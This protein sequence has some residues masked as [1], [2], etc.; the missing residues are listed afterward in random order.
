MARVLERCAYCGA[1]ASTVE[2]EHVIP[3]CLYPR[4]R[5]ASRV[6]RLTV[7]SCGRCNRGWSDD[8]A[9]F[10]NVLLLAGMPNSAVQEVWRTSTQRS[11]REVDG[12]RRIRDLVDLMV[13][14]QV[15][16]E[17]RWMIYPGRDPRVIRVVRKIVR[18]LS[19][20]HGVGS[21]IADERVWA[22]ILKY[23]IPEYLVNTVHFHHREGDIVEY[24]YEAYDVG[25]VTSMW[26]LKFY[27]SRV[28]VAAIARTTG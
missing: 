10:R 25:D 28:F 6:Q 20:H 2:R 7:P 8:E 1:G 5:A 18:G 23:P 12:L 9:H 19:H 27:E 26:L 16:G 14:V 22:D 17:D 15:E 13:P 21:A 4:S 24:W 11:F 3:R